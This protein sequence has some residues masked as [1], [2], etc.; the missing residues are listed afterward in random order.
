MNIKRV[1]QRIGAGVV[2]NLDSEVVEVGEN[3]GRRTN[4]EENEPILSLNDRC[5]DGMASENRAKIKVHNLPSRDEVSSFFNGTSLNG[6]SRSIGVLKQIF[7][8]SSHNT[9][10]YGDLWAVID[11]L[12]CFSCGNDLLK[13]VEKKMCRE[14]GL[15]K[16]VSL[17]RHHVDALRSCFIIFNIMPDGWEAQ[18]AEDFDALERL[19]S[20]KGMD[21]L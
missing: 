4:L 2:N 16:E 8:G 20:R 18:S 12:K 21:L 17:P 1:E 5:I 3:L 11:D 10:T 7:S 15:K 9:I 6:K 13:A 19:F 14:Y